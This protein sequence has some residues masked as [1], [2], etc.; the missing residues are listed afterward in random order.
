MSTSEP[1][2]SRACTIASRHSLSRLFFCRTCTRGCVEETVL[3]RVNCRNGSRTRICKV[4]YRATSLT[5][6]NIVFVFDEARVLLETRAKQDCNFMELMRALTH[7]PTDKKMC[8]PLSLMTDTVAKIL[9]LAPMQKSDASGRATGLSHGIFP[10]FF[11]FQPFALFP[12]LTLLLSPLSSSPLPPSLPPSPLPPPPSPAARRPPAARPRHI[13]PDRSSTR[14][15]AS[16]LLLVQGSGQGAAAGLQ[17]R[18][19]A[20]AACCGGWGC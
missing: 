13:R 4:F 16:P 20:V 17:G 11:F 2:L 9:N 10:P 8:C 15:G 6:D 18:R 14:G 1:V 3:V 5:T 19:G 12:P 7:F